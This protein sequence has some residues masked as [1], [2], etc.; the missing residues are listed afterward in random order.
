MLGLLCGF[1]PGLNCL[2]KLSAQTGHVGVLN[3]VT[4]FFRVVVVLSIGVVVVLSLR[5]FVVVVHPC[6]FTLSSISL[7]CI[8]LAGK[9]R[10]PTG[11]DLACRDVTS[12][13]AIHDCV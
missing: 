8:C 9:L 5:L 4:C 10:P 11:G 7:I 2:G 12:G 6:L 13:I 1:H 3:C